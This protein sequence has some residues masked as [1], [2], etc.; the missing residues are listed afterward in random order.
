MAGA[1]ALILSAKPDLKEA[2]VRE[3]IRNSAD[4]VGPI[5]YDN[6][7]NDR[8]GH[9]RLNVLRAVKAAIQTDDRLIPTGKHSPVSNTDDDSESEV[10]LLAENEPE[11]GTA[12]SPKAETADGKEAVPAPKATR[13]T[14]VMAVAPDIEGLDD[15]AIASYGHLPPA[16][17]TVHGRDDRRSISNTA[18]YPWRVT[19]SLLIT[20]RDNS[21]WI[22]TGW[23]I[24]PN[25]LV[26]AGH[27]VFI[28]DPNKPDRHGWVKRIEVMPGRDGSKLPFGMTISEIFHSVTGWTESGH[29]EYDYGAIKISTNLGSVVGTFGFGVLSRS[30]LL[31]T[32]GNLAGY[33]SDKPRGTLWYDNNRIASVTTRKVYYDID[34]AGGQSGAAV[35]RIK[36]GKRTAFGVHAY[37]GARTNSATRITTPVFQNLTNWNEG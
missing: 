5:P 19:S 4:K 36:S 32:T 34:T 31:R 18:N 13:A 17:E 26:T 23:F 3:I 22:G 6:G 9:G 15:I 11:T 29:H 10:T 27:V 16:P 14:D 8:M 24:G 33:P 28:F 7:R 30:E 20:A 12:K 37:G 2:E 25:T 35:Y 21:R 1:A